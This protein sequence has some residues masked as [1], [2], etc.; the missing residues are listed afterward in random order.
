MNSTVKVF[1]GLIASICT[2]TVF[3]HG[4][5]PQRLESAS[6]SELVAY[7]FTA[8][9]GFKES[10]LYEVEC[11]KDNFRTPAECEAIPG[12]FWVRP[13]AKRYVKIQIRTTGDGIYLACTKQVPQDEN[14][15]G[16]VTRVCARWGVGMS[17]GSKKSNGA[18][19]YKSTPSSAVQSRNR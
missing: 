13:H 12:E 9:N 8:T 5:S 18:K 11:F 2:T 17:P 15:A 16:V 3:A 4:L 14:G 10:Q 1:I 6:G 19:Q 7:K